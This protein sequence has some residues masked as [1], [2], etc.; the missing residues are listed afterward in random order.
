[1]LPQ[2]P[3]NQNKKSNPNQIYSNT[4]LLCD[5]RTSFKSV[6]T[7]GEDLRFDDGHQTVLLHTL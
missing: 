3:N 6:I 1:M 4:N 7:V 5:L 2:E